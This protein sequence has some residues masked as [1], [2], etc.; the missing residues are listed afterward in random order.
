M[1]WGEITKSAKVSSCWK[2]NLGHL[3]CAASALPLSYDNWTTTSPQNLLYVL[4]WLF[5]SSVTAQVVLKCQVVGWVIKPRQRQVTST[6][7]VSINITWLWH[8]QCEW[9]ICLVLKWLL[10]MQLIGTASMLLL[11]LLCFMYSTTITCFYTFFSI[12][13]STA[14]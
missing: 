4:L 7:Y 12:C 14:D 1:F 10:H 11:A 13:H 3:A 8:S 2:L 6:L 5:V 9:I